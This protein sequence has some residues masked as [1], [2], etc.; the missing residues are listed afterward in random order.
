MNIVTDINQLDFL[1]VYTYADYLTWYFDERLELIK[2]YIHRMSPAPLNLHQRVVT[3]IGGEIQHYLKRKKC[4]VYIAPF[5]VRFPKKGEEINDNKICTVLQPDICVVCD[6][7]KLDEKGC[8]GA[9]DMI[10]EVVSVSSAKKD[11]DYKFNIYEESGVAEYW[12]VYPKDKSITIYLLDEKGKY[13]LK[14]IFTNEGKV[15]VTTVAGLE[16]DMEDVFDI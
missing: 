11:L 6:S 10:V 15:P 4:K 12:L 14:Y 13:Q 9:P 2:G 3:N 8:V 1:K 7:S 16:I 5:D